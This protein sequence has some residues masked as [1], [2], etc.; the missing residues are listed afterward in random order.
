MRSADGAMSEQSLKSGEWT[1]LIDEIVADRWFNPETNTVM[2]V[3]YDRIEFDRSLDGAEADLVQ[4]MELGSSFAVVCDTATY[5]ALGSRVARNMSELG[6]VEAIV[7]DHP[8]ADLAT[9]EQL[10][11]K[12]KK[13]EELSRSDQGQ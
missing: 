8:H 3:D 11:E 7:L 5:D 12:I 1:K 13:Y 10:K 6:P 9:V 2:S 4:S